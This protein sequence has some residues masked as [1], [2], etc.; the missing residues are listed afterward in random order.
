[1]NYH[2]DQGRPVAD[3][4]NSGTCLTAITS[5]S[6][7]GTSFQVADAGYFMDGWGIGHVR[8]DLLQLSGTPRRA[9]IVTVDYATNTITV[10]AKLS[11]TRNQ[12]VSMGF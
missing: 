12:G 1:M 8:G 10:D 2:V 7:S 11:W 9:R 4:Q 5:P 6:G 3:D